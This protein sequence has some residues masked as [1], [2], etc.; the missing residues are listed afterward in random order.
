MAKKKTKKKVKKEEVCETFEVKGKGKE[1]VKTVCGTMEKKMASKA[2]LKRQDKILRNIL[3]GLG[4]IILLVIAGYFYINSLKYFGYRGIEGEV[5][6]EGGLIFYQISVPY[7]V[8]N[9][10]VIIYNVYLRNDPRKLDSIP[11]EGEIDFGRKFND[12]LYRLVV[13]V[14]D[15]FRCEGDGIISL[16]N[17]VNLKSIE[18]KV[19]GDENAS[20]DP[21]GRY[22]YATIVAGDENKITEIGPS[23]YELQVKECDILKVT[24]R[25]MVEMLVDNF[26]RK[27]S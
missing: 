5:V 24:E 3:I 20:C 15:E 8:I 2:E 26:E 27:N 16:A 22:M 17:M 18:V 4:I 6:S 7:R 25:F 11:F 9:G 23:C 12:F 13:N 1:K 10:D 14:E 19:V 21:K